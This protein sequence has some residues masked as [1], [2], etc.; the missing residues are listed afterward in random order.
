MSD[1]ELARPVGSILLDGVQGHATW[2]G[3]VALQQSLFPAEVQNVAEI[4]LFSGGLDSVAGLYVRG[5]RSTGTIVTVSACGSDVRGRAQADALECLRTLGVRTSWVKLQHQLRRTHRTRRT[6]ESSQ[7]SRSVLF[8]A[9]GAAVASTIGLE[10]FQTYETGIGCMNLPLSPAQ[11]GSQDTKAMHPFTL[12]AVNAL[13]AVVLERPVRVRVPFFFT[14]KGQLCRAAG[15]ALTSLAAVAMSCDEGEGHK[16]DAMEH[17]GICTSCV[18]RRVALS[19]AA[20]GQDPTKYRDIPSR[21]H[22]E[23]ELRTF[24]HHA[25]DLALCTSFEDLISLDPDAR[26]A[27]NPPIDPPVSSDE[28][29]ARTLALFG[30]YAKEISDFLLTSRPTLRPRP[31]NIRKE[32]ER[33]LFAAAG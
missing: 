27:S 18:F 4:A 25:R 13:F 5:Q 33:D 11:V 31:I 2:L 8:L 19:A 23:Y 6:M 32:N 26:H 15:P 7:R 9:M 29:E 22:G 30:A 10:T 12:N 1:A 20:T 14:T 17:C 16:T 28:A 24:E 3:S 21:E